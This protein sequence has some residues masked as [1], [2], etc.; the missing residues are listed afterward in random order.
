MI[1][2]HADGFI[3]ADT[4]TKFESVR[5]FITAASAIDKKK[6]I[7]DW[8][9]DFVIISVEKSSNNIGPLCAK[10]YACN[11]QAN[12]PSHTAKNRLRK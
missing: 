9:T 11:L 7:F 6:N 5:R 10:V 3:N 2:E 4:I 12:A 1:E 8:L